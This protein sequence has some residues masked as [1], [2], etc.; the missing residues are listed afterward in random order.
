MFCKRLGKVEMNCQ[1]SLAMVAVLVLSIFGSGIAACEDRPRNDRSLP[2]V[3]LEKDPDPDPEVIAWAQ[4]LDAVTVCLD[5]G[6][7]LKTCASA[8]ACRAECVAE[9]DRR[10][11]PRADRAAQLDAFEAVFITPGAVCR[12][13]AGSRQ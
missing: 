5:R 10:L 12:P 6:G 13:E 4:C 11:D 1:R 3:M 8:T 7:E 2:S 9:L